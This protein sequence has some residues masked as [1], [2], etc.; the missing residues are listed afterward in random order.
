MALDVDLDAAQ[1]ELDP[2]LAENLTRQLEQLSAEQRL[3]QLQR[4]ERSLLRLER[5]HVQSIALL[6]KLVEAAGNKAGG[7][8][9]P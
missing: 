5:L 8:D 3:D 4:L 9:K 7:G 2:A 1:L 6:K